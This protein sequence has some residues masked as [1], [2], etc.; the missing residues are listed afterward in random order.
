MKLQKITKPAKSPSPQRYD[1]A[2]G[3]AHGLELIGDRWALLILR[4]LMLGGRRFSQLRADLPGISANILTQRLGELEQRGL[5]VRKRLPPPAAAQVYELTA[6]GYEAEPIVQSL[7]RWAARSPFHDPTLRISAVSSL[8]SL[9][10]LFQPARARGIDTTIGF[11]FGEEGYRGHLTAGGFDI[12]RGEPDGVA[13]LFDG[14]PEALMAAVHG[15][16]PLPELTAAG[17]LTVKGDHDLAR[18]FTKWF[19]LP[20]KLIR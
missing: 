16:V 14:R 1:D 19:P 17:V 6:W 5:L 7:G 20:Q 9:R 15:G 4:E 2:C 13:V 10:T 11:R 18:R 3:T 8:L 12:M